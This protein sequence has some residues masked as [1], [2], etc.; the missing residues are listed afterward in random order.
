MTK[1]HFL[2]GLLVVGALCAIVVAVLVYSVV[3]HRIVPIQDSAQ[4]NVGTHIVR[5][6]AMEE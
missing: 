3:S 4:N 1:K 2:Q 6:P 5:P